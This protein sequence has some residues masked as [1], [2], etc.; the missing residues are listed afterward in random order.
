VI[1]QQLFES[2]QLLRDSLDVV[3]AIYA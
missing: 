2:A 3:Q 1:S